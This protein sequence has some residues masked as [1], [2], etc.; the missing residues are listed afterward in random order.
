MRFRAWVDWLERGRPKRHGSGDCVCVCGPEQI[1]K[2]NSSE[3]VF[4]YVDQRPCTAFFGKDV[5]EGF[6]L[7]V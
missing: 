3:V 5:D 7:L 4:P 6:G 1:R 2:G